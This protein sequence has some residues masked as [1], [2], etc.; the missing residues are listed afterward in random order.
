M[1]VDQ[2]INKALDETHLVILFEIKSNCEKR[3]LVCFKIH[4]PDCVFISR[5]T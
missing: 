3:R 4:L 2:T 1:I 5:K